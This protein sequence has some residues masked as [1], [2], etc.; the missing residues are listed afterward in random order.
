MFLLFII[1][2]IVNYFL[3]KIVIIITITLINRTLTLM[4]IFDVQLDDSQYKRQLLIVLHI[5]T[6]FNEI[7][8]NS[9]KN[10]VKRT[11]VFGGKAAPGY[12]VNKYTI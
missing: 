2:I 9:Y 8:D 3:F 4:L 7:I 11:I 12:H 1:V 5:F 10:Y 6:L